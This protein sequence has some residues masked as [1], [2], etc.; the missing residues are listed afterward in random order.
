MSRPLQL[1]TALGTLLF[2]GCPGEHWEETYSPDGRQPFDLYAL[3]E[4]LAARPGGLT[5]LT[6]TA[7]FARLDTSRGSDYLFV[8][9]LPFY[10]EAAVTR[11]LDYVARGNNAFLAANAVPEDLAYHLF[12]DDCYYGQ[13][14]DSTGYAGEERFPRVAVDS[15]VAYRYPSGDSFHLINVRYWQTRRVGMPTISDRLLCDTALDNQVLGS[16]DTLGINF[17]RVGWGEGDFY[18]H[19]NPVLLTNWFVLDSTAYR[20]PASVLS[21]LGSGPVYWDE[22]HRRYLTDPATVAADEREYTGG[23]NLLNGNRTLLYVQ[24]HPALALA[25]YTL[26]GGALL[27]V[28]FRGRRRRRIIPT[29][30]VRDNFSRR[31]IDTVSRLVLQKGN[32]AALAQ[33]EL[34]SLRFHL[35]QYRGIRWREGEPLPGDLGE[36]LGLSDEVMDRARSQIRLVE[37]GKALAEGDL[38][39]FYRAVEPLYRR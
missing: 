5:D 32:H 21:V 27:Y 33:R 16:L 13:F 14:E 34:S 37:R 35:L 28:V 19:S 29:L 25:W 31:L 15:F 1:L 39:R 2:F 20:Y 26:L 11:L 23:R 3:H 22:V 24:R 8:G 7:A 18:F 4:L 6:D 10:D 38:L 9:H 17:I 12:G 30:P 36:R